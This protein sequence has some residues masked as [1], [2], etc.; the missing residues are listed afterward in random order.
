MAQQAGGK[1]KLARAS[2]QKSTNA[3]KRSFRVANARKNHIKRARQSCGEAFAK[4][5]A[6]YYAKTPVP[7]TKC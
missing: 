6:D 1:H 3:A 2:R 5:L 4:K 7:G